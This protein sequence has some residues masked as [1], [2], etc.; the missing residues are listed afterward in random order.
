LATILLF[1]VS[2][3]WGCSD[4][5]CVTLCT[6]VAFRLEECSPGWGVTWEAFG[7]E[8]RAD[9]RLRCVSEWDTVRAD[10][11]AR[12]VPAAEDQCT[13]AAGD[14]AALGASECDVLRALYLE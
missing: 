1:V 10:L 5:P 9:W 3:L 12:E 6:D 13:D 8:T 4:D 11:E 14:L 7:A 2:A